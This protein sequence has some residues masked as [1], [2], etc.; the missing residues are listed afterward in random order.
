MENA[1]F[2]LAAYGIIWAF[3][4]GYLLVVMSRQ[5]RLSREIELLKQMLKD[6]EPSRQGD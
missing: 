3:L 6:R 1:G 5:K 2:L 4:F